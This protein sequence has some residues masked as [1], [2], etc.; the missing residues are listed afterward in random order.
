M[1]VNLTRADQQTETLGARCRTGYFPSAIATF[2][3]AGVIVN[4][5]TLGGQSVG[6]HA[7]GDPSHQ[8]VRNDNRPVTEVQVGASEKAEATRPNVRGRRQSEVRAADVINRAA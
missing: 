3:H 5:V 6:D 1:Q 4:N 8:S 2:N 7:H